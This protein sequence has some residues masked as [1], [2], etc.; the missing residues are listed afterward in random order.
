MRLVLFI[1]Y[2]ID[3]KQYMYFRSRYFTDDTKLFWN[4]SLENTLQKD[5]DRIFLWI[6]I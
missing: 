4:S 1:V 3:L 2:T 5:F 6:K